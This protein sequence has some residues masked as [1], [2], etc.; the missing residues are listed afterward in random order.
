MHQTKCWGCEKE[1]FY[2][3]KKYQDINCPNCGIQNSI[4]NPLDYEPIDDEEEVIEMSPDVNDLKN[5]LKNEDLQQGDIVTFVN[6]GEI[7][8][9]DFSKAQDGS[10]VKTVLQMLVEIPDGKNKIYTP[11]ATTRNR[12]KEIWGKDT[13]DWVGKKAKVTFIKQL[14]FGK[15]IDVLVLEPVE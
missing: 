13:E 8:S 1:F 4:Y 10:A 14:A 3:D 12:L 15:T 5:N 2:E 6:A 11:N 7:K 9:V